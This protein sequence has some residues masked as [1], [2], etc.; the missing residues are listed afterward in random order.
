MKYI[1]EYA[2]LIVILT[3]I[4][5]SLICNYYLVIRPS[6]VPAI[7]ASPRMSLSEGAHLNVPQTLLKDDC[8][9]PPGTPRPIGKEFSLTKLERLKIR[10]EKLEVYLS[11]PNIDLTHAQFQLDTILAIKNKLKFLQPEMSLRIR[12]LVENVMSREKIAASKCCVIL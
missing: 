7:N 1:R 4:G 11:Q 12:A 10:V 6:N 2:A 9:L 5:I 3:V 8:D